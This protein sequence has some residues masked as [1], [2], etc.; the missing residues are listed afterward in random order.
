MEQ[1]YQ[2]LGITSMSSREEIDQRYQLL[3]RE[4][5]EKMFLEGEEGARAA[6]FLRDLDIAYQDAISAH[7]ENSSYQNGT[8]RYA[9]VEN[10][11]KV[12][13]LEKA[14]A[15]LDGYS[16]RDTD[17]H[18]YQSNLYYKKNW[19]T[20]SKKQLELS[21]QLDPSNQRARQSLEGLEKIMQGEKVEQVR[22]EQ[23][24]KQQQQQYG[25]QQMGGMGCNCCDCLC[26]SLLCNMCGGC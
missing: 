24:Q 4:Y 7:R 23:Q 22:V 11:L 2:I 21:L 16:G 10:A 13:N 6:N 12:G 15:I 9:E 8:S 5:T 17:W 3:K 25:G 26:A 20:D 18:Y 19:F 1:F 14:Q